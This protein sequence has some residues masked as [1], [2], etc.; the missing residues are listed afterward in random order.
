MS[1]KRDPKTGI[2]QLDIRKKG[3]PPVRRSADTTERAKAQEL[4]DRLVADL[5]RQKHLGVAPSKSWDDAVR[6]YIDA[7]MRRGKR[8]IA[9]D[10][11]RLRWI[12]PRFAGMQLKDITADTIE[13]ALRAKELDSKGNAGGTINRYGAVVSGV[14][15]TAKRKG[16][17]DAVPP[18]IKRRE[19]EDT[20]LWISREQAAALVAELPDHLAAMTR[21]SLATGM[22][23]HNVSYLEWAKVDAE[24]RIAWVDGSDA[25]GKRTLRVPLSDDALSVLEGQRGKHPRYVFVFQPITPRGRATSREPFPIL[26]PAGAAWM[27]AK[28][29]AGIDPAFRWH[30]LRHTWAT[31]HVQAGTPVEVLQ[32]LGGWRDYRMV[33][34]YAKFAPDHLASYAGNAG[35]SIAKPGAGATASQPAPVIRLASA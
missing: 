29:R 2:W 16:W 24:R 5:W 7:A 30:D 26:Q 12:S 27:K 13:D 10:K 32:R 22:R 23:Q 35:L 31:W 21:F 20:G 33:A 18:I 3:F 11:D 17:I 19:R 15:H 14:L 6:E 28:L 8:S 25:K 1:I 9:D 34:K 4:H